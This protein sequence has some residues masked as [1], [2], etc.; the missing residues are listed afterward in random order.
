MPHCP[1]LMHATVSGSMTRTVS[2][3][4]EHAL[5]RVSSTGCA[6]MPR[7]G[8]TGTAAAEPAADAEAQ[9]V[10]CPA[11]ATMGGGAAAAAARALGRTAPSLPQIA[12][13]C[14]ALAAP[15]TLA[16]GDGRGSRA[17][18]GEAMVAVRDEVAHRVVAQCER[19]QPQRLTVRH[20]LQTPSATAASAVGAAVAAARAS[21][22]APPSTPAGAGVQS[23]G[24]AI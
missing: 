21:G 17:C 23:I 5:I 14:S 22:R 10:T 12:Q 19:A 9:L 8:H 20:K 18:R 13:A 6:I 3:H 1:G 4:V 2:E 15:S 16:A 11:A 24:C 7:G